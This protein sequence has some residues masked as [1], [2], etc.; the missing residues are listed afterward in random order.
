MSPI[1][2]A[3][4][5]E[6]FAQAYYDEHFLVPDRNV[7]N[8]DETGIYFDTPPKYTWAAKGLPATLVGLEKN[9]MRL[10]ALLTARKSGMY[11]YI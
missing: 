11:R 4:R 3:A 10:T 5:R 1:A 9:S 8:A 7:L 6:A 2:L